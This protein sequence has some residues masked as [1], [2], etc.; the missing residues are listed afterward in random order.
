M[1]TKKWTP[2]IVLDLIE[3]WKDKGLLPEQVTAA[4]DTDYC[5]GCVADLYRIYQERLR[6]LNA[7]DFGDLLL[8]PLV[9]FKNHADVL[10]EYQKKFKYILVDEYQDTNVAQYLLLRLL[11]KGHGNICCVGMMINP[12]IPGAVRK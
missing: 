1:D 7:V 11:A 2:G 10:A 5:G 3:R 9:L 12:F 8:L 6:S 4:E